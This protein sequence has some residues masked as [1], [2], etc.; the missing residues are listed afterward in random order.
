M[1]VIDAD[2]PQFS[3]DGNIDQMAKITYAFCELY[4]FFQ[5]KRRAIDHDRCKSGADRSQDIFHVMAV[6]KMEAIYIPAVHQ[7]R[8]Y[9]V[10]ELGIDQIEFLGRYRQYRRR[11]QLFGR[12]KNDP[13]IHCLGDIESTDCEI[14]ALCHR[15]DLL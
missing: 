4:V 14:V 7:K 13:E 5:G 12:F 11:L 1:I 15:K 9:V 3:F 2:H 10:I 6:I 8:L